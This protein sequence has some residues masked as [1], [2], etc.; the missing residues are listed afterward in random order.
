MSG[1][2]VLLDVGSTNSRGWLVSD[3]E[4]VARRALNV[5]V[6]DTATSGSNAPVRLAVAKL[7][8]SL[9]PDQAVTSIAGAGMISSAQ[10]IREV[11]HVAA[12]ASVADV[13]RA[14]ARLEDPELAPLPIVLTP[15]VMTAGR[16]RDLSADVMRGEEALTFGLL[17]TG[18]LLPGECLLNSG[19]HW[20]IIR[21]DSEARI[22]GSQTTLGGEVMHAVQAHTLLAASLPQVPIEDP[23]IAW[24]EAG[25]AATDADGLLRAL[26]GTRLL[27][28][29]GEASAAQRLS[30]LAGACVQEGI[31]GFERSRGLPRGRGIAVAGPDAMCRAWCHLLERAGYRCRPLGRERTEAAFIAGLT[32]I[33]AAVR[34]GDR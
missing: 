11:P 12:P 17:A 28:Q 2:V 30:W 29:L 6:R 23:D 9:S 8:A 32:A 34:A 13:A 4:V 15:G 22:A 33:L 20:K 19:S 26:F 1:P 3:G 27:D 31:R 16:A 7:I 10:G 18:G 5:G 14:A 21:T 24:V 25:A